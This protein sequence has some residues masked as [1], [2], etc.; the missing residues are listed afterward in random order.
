M[1]RFETSTI[2]KRLLPRRMWTISRLSRKTVRCRRYLA[3]KLPVSACWTIPQQSR[4]VWN[5]SSILS[6]VSTQ[7]PKNP[8]IYMLGRKRGFM[9]TQWITCLPAHLKATWWSRCESR[10]THTSFHGGSQP[11]EVIFN[12]LTIRCKIRENNHLKRIENSFSVMILIQKLAYPYDL[13]QFIF[14]KFFA[15]FG[16]SP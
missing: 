1:R 4:I 11:S 14:F 8:K 15:R 2:E 12:C 13:Q 5:G 7:L 16:A 10:R 6:P 3:N 9:I